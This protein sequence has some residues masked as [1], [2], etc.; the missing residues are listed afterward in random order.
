LVEEIERQNQKST[1]TKNANDDARFDY[2]TFQELE[3]GKHEIVRKCKEL[4]TKIF[5][6]YDF[7]END[8]KK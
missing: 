7:D 4:A 1:P 2:S 5:E 6:D 3:E 8:K